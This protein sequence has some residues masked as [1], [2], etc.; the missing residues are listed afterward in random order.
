MRDREVADVH[1]LVTRQNTVA[2]GQPHTFDL[3][4]RG[5]FQGMDYSTVYT[6]RAD[7]TAAEEREGPAPSS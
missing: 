7:A 2:G 1:V 4:G 6:I 5:P 3:I